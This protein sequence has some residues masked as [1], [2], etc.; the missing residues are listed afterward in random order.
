V[1][2]A[3]SLWWLPPESGEK[4]L[5]VL[6]GTAAMNAD[7]TKRMKLGGFQDVA[8]NLSRRLIQDQ[9][10]RAVFRRVVREQDD[11]MLEGA[12]LHRRRSE[13]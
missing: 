13:E 1:N 2:D 10:K 7:V 8:D 4:Q 9:S 12:V 11:R 6:Y 3:Q 5:I